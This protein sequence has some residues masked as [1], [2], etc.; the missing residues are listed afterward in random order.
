VQTWGKTAEHCSQYLSKGRS[1]YVEGRLQTRSWDDK[2][3][4]KKQYKTEIVAQRVVFLGGEPGAARAG[5]P[6]SRGPSGG[7][8]PAPPDF[9][10]PGD[11]DIPF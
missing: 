3:S 1:V 7:A 2:E 6:P 5:G 9:A 4:G 10:A 11:D 8:E